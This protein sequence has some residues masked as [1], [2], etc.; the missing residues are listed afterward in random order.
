MDREEKTDGSASQGAKQ[1]G[2]IRARWAWT[3]PCVWTDR[4]LTALEN[5]VKGGQWFSLIDK[6]WDERNLRAAFVRVKAN[7]GAA[8]VD[9]V[10]IEDFERKLDEHVATVSGQLRDGTYRPQPVARRYI[11]KLGSREKRPLGVPTV[12]DRMVEGAARHV[13][14][15][16]FEKDFLGCSYGFR[17]GR[18]CKDAL[19]EVVRLLQE[20]YL[21]VLEVDF[22]KYFDS[23]PWTPLIERVGERI[24]DGRMLKLIGQFLQQGVREEGR[25]WEPEE[26]TPQGAVISPLLANIYLHPLDK[27]L[28]AGGYHVIRFA[29]DLVVLCR[30]RAEA[31][32]ALGELT[33]WTT[34]A[35]LLL[36]PDKTQIVDMNPTGAHFDFLG[37]RFKRTRKGTLNWW[38]RPKSMQ[39]L[40]DQLRAETR[41]A[42]GRSLDEIIQRI[43]PKLRGWFEYFKHAHHTTFADI[44]RWVRMRLRSILRKRRGLRGRGRGADHQR[45]PNAYFAEHG[46]FSTVTTYAYACQSARR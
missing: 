37:Y 11:P 27:R 9:H 43:N 10:S 44:D 18:G 38:P 46:L 23:I 3:E 39:K 31:E 21:Y 14:E 15:P 32:G 16:I 42:N 35:G 17:P 5:G 33:R 36:H 41:R 13:I 26:G 25:I 22:R 30:N 40:K 28:T 29:D 8:G 45:W 1:A 20:G 19:R 7:K 4:M 6:V 12:R 34:E 24:S 2:D